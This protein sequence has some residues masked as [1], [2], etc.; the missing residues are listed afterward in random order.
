MS[1]NFGCDVEESD[2]EELKNKIIELEER[3]EKIEGGTK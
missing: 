2:V 3:I 1:C